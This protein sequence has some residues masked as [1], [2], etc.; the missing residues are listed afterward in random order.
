M[1]AEQGNFAAAV[2]QYKAA[3]Q[4]QPHDGTLYEQLAQCLLETEQYHDA[5]QAASVACYRAP[6]VLA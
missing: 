2:D 1:F 3:L 5:Y 6:Q 4:L